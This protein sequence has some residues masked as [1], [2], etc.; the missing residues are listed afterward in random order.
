[1]YPNTVSHTVKFGK[2]DEYDWVGKEDLDEKIK[3]MDINYND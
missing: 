3:K 1:M 2:S